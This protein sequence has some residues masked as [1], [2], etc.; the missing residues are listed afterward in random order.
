MQS[1]NSS[2]LEVI[3]TCSPRNFDFVK[4]LGADAVFDYNDPSA[5]AKIREHTQN[6][7]YYAFD[8]Y[9]EGSSPQI[10]ADALSSNTSS[11]KPKYGAILTAKAP[12]EDVESLYTLG[13][14]AIGEDFT[15]MG[16]KFE[17]K[18]EDFEFTKSFLKLSE[19]L[20][21]E[22][23]IKPHRI[24]VAGGLDDIASGCQAMKEGKVS[25]T[26]IVYVIGKE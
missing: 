19:K 24:E 6:K 9:S 26:K 2:G 7:L 3:T 22:K 12:R 20:V 18:N 8:T 11:Q 13:Y 21:A 1:H 15:I 4:S 25:G 23:K 16:R 17:A 10:C 5:G 14:T